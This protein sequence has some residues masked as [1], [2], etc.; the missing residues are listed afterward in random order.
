MATR[1]L[2][3]K[4][5]NVFTSDVLPSIELDEKGDWQKMAKKNL[6]MFMYIRKRGQD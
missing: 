4:G 2:A 6:S 5:N 3:L 1:A